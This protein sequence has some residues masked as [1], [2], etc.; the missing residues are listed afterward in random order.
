MA[1]YVTGP[2]LGYLAASAAKIILD[3]SPWFDSADCSTLEQIWLADTDGSGTTDILYI[4][5]SEIHVYLNQSGNSLSRRKTLKGLPAPGARSVSVVD[6]L[7][8]GTS[9]L[10]W[11][12]PLRSQAQHPLRYVDLMRGKKPHLLS[13][14]AN[15]RGA[16]TV[17][18]Y[19]SSTEFYLADRAAGRAWIT[20]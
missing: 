18:E 13:R 12:S 5:A 1:R 9:C 6:F 16:E 19:A 4:S 14:I 17:I 7:G 10:V 11:S 2:N 15:N 8:R 3:Q 20:A